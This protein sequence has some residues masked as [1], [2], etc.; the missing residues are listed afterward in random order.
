M[1]T[2]RPKTHLQE[3]LPDRA[4]SRGLDFL[5][6]Q[7]LTLDE[8]LAFNEVTRLL[9]LMDKGEDVRVADLGCGTGQLIKELACI[10]RLYQEISGCRG[11]FNACGLDLNPLVGELDYGKAVDHLNRFIRRFKSIRER[12]KMLELL[13]QDFW[14]STEVD[15]KTHDLAE[16]LPNDL[17]A[18]DL[19]IS[20]ETALYLSD[21]LGFADRVIS[22]MRDGGFAMISG[23]RE[24]LVRIT[25]TVSGVQI[26]FASTLPTMPTS[27]YLGHS[28]LLLH[29][30]CA[31]NERPFEEFRFTASKYL[32]PSANSSDKFLILSCY[33]FTPSVARRT[34]LEPSL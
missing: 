24:N 19:V 15:F 4:L 5:S 6:A 30:A 1:L 3:L 10:L 2:D 17:C 29:R 31:E 21:N 7:V 34:V 23:I 33:N 16:P 13:N 22:R 20:F 12:V 32:N 14:C 11:R 27:T 8:H 28:S 9:R 25:D 18:L 26:P